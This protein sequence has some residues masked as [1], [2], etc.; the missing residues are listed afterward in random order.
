MRERLLQTNVNPTVTFAIDRVEGFPA[1]D[2][3]VTGKLIGRLKI[4]GV[5]RPVTFD[6]TGTVSGDTVSGTG[7]TTIKQT[8]FG[9]RPFDIANFVKVEDPVDLRLDF[10]AKQR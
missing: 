1:P 4:V 5:E 6:V 3:P 8:D 7:T 2:G 10:V 9:L